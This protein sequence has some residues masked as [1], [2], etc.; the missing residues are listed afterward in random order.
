MTFSPE[1][2]KADS[3]IRVEAVFDIVSDVDK[4]GE[5]TVGVITKCD[6]TQDVAQV[7]VVVSQKTL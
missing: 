2:Y 5:R 6:I 3:E 4:N 7:C 1:G